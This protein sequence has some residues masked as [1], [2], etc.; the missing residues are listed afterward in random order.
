[1]YKF[2]F[3]NLEVSMETLMDFFNSLGLP[4]EYFS[5]AV[6]AYILFLMVQTNCP[7]SSSLKTM[8]VNV[9]LVTITAI[10]SPFFNGWFVERSK[11]HKVFS[12]DPQRLFGMLSGNI[13]WL[14]LAA[15]SEYMQPLY[16]AYIVVGMMGM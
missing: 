1:M 11:N 13:L 10:L 12:P 8:L 4:N 9:A 6:Y 14:Y 16:A 15:Q 5:Y 3:F 7:S 2:C